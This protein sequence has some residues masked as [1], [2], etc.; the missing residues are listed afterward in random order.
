M[1]VSCSRVV[2]PPSTLVAWTS[3]QVVCQLTYHYQELHCFWRPGSVLDLLVGFCLWCLSF[4][5]DLVVGFCLWL[6]VH[7]VVFVSRVEFVHLV[8]FVSVVLDLVEVLVQVFVH[9]AVVVVVVVTSVEPP[10]DVAGV[11]PIAKSA[12]WGW[13][14]CPIP[15]RQ[16]LPVDLP[17]SPPLQLLSPYSRA[18]SDRSDE[19]GRSCRR[20]STAGGRLVFRW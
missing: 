6:F 14:Q 8:V 4:V 7:L 9:V 20:R 15:F 17:G 3:L 10:G 19:Y 11:H 18:S 1:D 16:L 12:Q 13:P 2:E 5:S